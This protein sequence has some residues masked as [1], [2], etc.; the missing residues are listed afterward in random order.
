[1]NISTVEDPIEY[2]LRGIAQTQVNREKGY[3]FAL[4]LRA[5]MRQDPDVLLVG[6]TRDQK[7]PKPPSKRPSPA[8]WCLPPC[9]ATTRP[10]PSPA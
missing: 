5:F 2:T 10:V 7:P 6:E 3:D 8:T 4:A 1:M 9:I